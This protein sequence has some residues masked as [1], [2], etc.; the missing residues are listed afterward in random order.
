MFRTTVVRDSAE[1]MVVLILLSY[2]DIVRFFNT[3]TTGIVNVPHLRISIL[4]VF[5]MMKL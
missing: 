2:G 1:Y 4:Q 5:Q 3:I